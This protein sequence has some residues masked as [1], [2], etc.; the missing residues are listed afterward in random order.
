MFIVPCF[1]WLFVACILGVIVVCVCCR[2]CFGCSVLRVVCLSSCAFV[3]AD[4]ICCVRVVCWCLGV[5]AACVYV[6]C[7]RL[8]FV[9]VCC[10]S[11]C[12]CVAVYCV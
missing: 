4:R 10:G 5:F 6:G 12:L 9:C 3:F 8:V 11:L 1:D 2:L 7:F